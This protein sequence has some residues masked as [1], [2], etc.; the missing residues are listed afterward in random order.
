MKNLKNTALL[1]ASLIAVFVVAG[2]GPLISFG[3]D[4]PADDSYTLSY[5]KTYDGGKDRLA[6]IYVDQPLMTGG[7]GGEEIAVALPGNKRTVLKGVRWVSHISDLLRDYMT[8]SLRA[9][10]NAN[11][12]SEGGLDIKVGCR[13]GVKLWAM[14]YAPGDRPGEDSINVSLELSLVRLKDAN[15]VGHETFSRTR[16]VG[17]DSG[18]GV[19]SGFNDAL[20]DI[21]LD[22]GAW[23]TSNLEG[24]TR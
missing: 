8:Q 5:P 22:Y 6:A 24:C 1:T 9:E 2:C 19:V 18:Q 3:N 4:G 7:L 23:V 12:V 13:L 14:E 16:V 20:N 11:I 15:L 21:A 10:T 17:S